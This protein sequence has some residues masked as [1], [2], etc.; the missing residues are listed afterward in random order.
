MNITPTWCST[1]ISHK[2]AFSDIHNKQR[3]FKVN[4]KNTTKQCQDLPKVNQN[5]KTT[6]QIM[7]WYPCCQIWTGPTYSAM[8]PVY[9]FRTLAG[10]EKNSAFCMNWEIKCIWGSGCTVRPSMGSERPEGKALEKFTVLNLKL[11][12]YSPLNI[13]KLKLSV[14]NK[15]LIIM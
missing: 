8:P 9:T 5:L 1:K 6:W 7:W 11:V 3:I 13:I 4:N 15:N 10:K 12:W 2:V 14:S